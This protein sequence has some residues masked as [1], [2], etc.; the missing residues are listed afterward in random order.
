MQ[1]TAKF[2]ESKILVVDDEL[3][4]RSAL[5]ELLREEGYSVRNAADGYKAL[6]QLESWSPDLI[7]TDVKMPGMDGIELMQKTRDR[8]DGVGVVVMTAFGSVENAVAAM[9]QG[10][11]D[12]LTKPVHFPELL[13]VVRRVLAHN[14]LRRENARLRAQL[15]AEPVDNDQ[16]EWIGQSKPAREMLSLVRQVADSDASVLIVGESGTGKE[17]VARALHAWGER[18][19]GP[20]VSL[21]CAA[22]E[23]D[24][25]EGELFGREKGA[26][27]ESTT[28]QAGRLEQ[29]DGGTLFLDEVGELPPGTQVKLLQFLQERKFERVGGGEVLGGDVR[30]IAATHR[31]LHSDVLEGRFREDLYYRLNVITLRVP[32]LRQR[33]E[34]LPALSMH[35]LNKYARKNRK[36][37]R[38]FNDRALGVLIH[39]DWPGNV[40]QLENCVERAVVVCQGREI[41][42]KHLPREIMV[43]SRVSEEMPQV[44]GTS[45]AELEKFAILKTL[46]H[47]RGSTSKAAEILGISPRKIQY[48]LAEYRETDPSG[49]PAVIR[50]RTAGEE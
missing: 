14:D 23:D 27:T 28:R 7:I 37:I 10:A 43:S 42:P 44:P 21:H 38:G 3:S 29:A 16:V 26:I 35:F 20:F 32:T 45:M 25:L 24:V 4:A 5:S 15:D 48:R 36:Q 13:V 11:D 18:R 22:L 9:Q 17:L 8:L 34:D 49:V 19:A 39:Y 31:D 47:V 6:G 46:E 41:E 40:R 2:A 1:D 12:Y 50:E 30:V 33:R